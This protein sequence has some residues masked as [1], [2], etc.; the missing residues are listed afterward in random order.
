[1]EFSYPEEDSKSSCSEET[2]RSEQN[3][4]M[5]GTGRFYECVFCKRGFPTAQALGGHMNIHRRD[6][7]K[8]TKSNFPSASSSKVDEI[9]Y[10]DLRFYNSEIEGNQGNYFSTAS[11]HQVKNNFH[12]IYFPPP[13]WGARPSHN[14]YSTQ[15]SE[16]LCVQNQRDRDV[17]GEDHWSRSFSS[18][19]ADSLCERE[20][21]GKV[22]ESSELQDELDLELR[23]GH[24]P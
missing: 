2:D 21:K 22:E 10:S 11:D 1:M 20:S 18:L 13:S 14:S 7:S 15:C 8:S 16:V 6:R 12:P 5:T 19:Y 24:D 23:L 9:K 3:D 4:D 17:F